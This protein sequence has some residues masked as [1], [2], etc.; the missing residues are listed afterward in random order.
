MEPRGH[1][2]VSPSPGKPRQTLQSPDRLYK[3]PTDN[4]KP[5]KDNTKPQN[6]VRN[7]Q[8]NMQNPNI[9]DKNQ[10]YLTRVATNNI[11]TENIQYPILVTPSINKRMY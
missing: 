3:V 7:P 6:T 2:Q 8:T 9:L 10:A 5:R 1:G 4:T 11:L